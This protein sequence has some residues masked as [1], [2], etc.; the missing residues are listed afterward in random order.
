M[1]ETDNS[2]VLMARIG[3]AHGIRG[4]VR[5]KAFGDDP[6]SFTDYGE[7][8]TKSGDTTFEV[9]RARIQKTVVVTKFKGINDRN[10][11]EELNGVELFVHRD[12]LPELEDDE[13]YHDDLVGMAV[14][15]LE[16]TD[17]GK[18]VMVQDFGAGDLLE[19]R[20][21]R[22]PTFY[23]PFSKAFVPEIDIEN[24]VVKADLPDDYFS[25]SSSDEER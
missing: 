15:D 22:G 1:S 21:K 3:A 12:Q 24:R 20:P 16:G 18:V 13:F 14:T 7:L 11:A 23:M 6:L 25:V 17:L 4:E 5:V 10:A 2:L 19:V 9:E 8:I